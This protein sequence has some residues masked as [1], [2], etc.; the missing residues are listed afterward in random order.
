MISSLLCLALSSSLLCLALIGSVT[1]PLS[2][3]AGLL[4]FGFLYLLCC[5]LVTC[6]GALSPSF[7]FPFT[8]PSFFATLHMLALHRR[9]STSPSTVLA[10]AQGFTLAQRCRHYLHQ[11]L[12][13]DS[14][15]RRL[16]HWCF[17][18]AARCGRYYPLAQ[19]FPQA[20]YCQRCLHLVNARRRPCCYTP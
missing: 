13:S 12:S 15:R 4:G 6:R 2:P 11:E 14:S 3:I 7:F 1:F 18:L 5:C 8:V 16:V 17:R 10:L 9:S 19:A 20:K